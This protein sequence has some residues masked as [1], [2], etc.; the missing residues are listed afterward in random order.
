MIYSKKPSDLA[1]ASSK[2]DAT[3]PAGTVVTFT[4]EK[5]DDALVITATPKG[6]ETKTA[7]YSYSASDNLLFNADKKN[8][9]VDI[10][11]QLVLTYKYSSI[12]WICISRC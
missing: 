9:A 10:Q 12:I 3:I 2:A 1:G 6:G 11:F 4:V 7:T 5:T 8:T